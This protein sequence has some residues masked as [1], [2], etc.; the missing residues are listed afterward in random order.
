MAQEEKA[1]TKRAETGFALIDAPD[2]RAILDEAFEQF[3]LTRGELSRLKIPAGGSTTWEIED[4]KE[5]TGIRSCQELDVVV[6]GIMGNQ[7]AWWSTPVGEGG[8]DAPSCVSVDGSVGVGNNTV[9]PEA[10]RGMHKCADCPWSQWGSSRGGGGGKDCND[11]SLLFFIT[12]NEA[13]P[14]Y[15]QV[16]AT[17]LKPLKKYGLALVSARIKV[18]SLVTRLALSK[19]VSGGGHSYSTLTLSKVDDLDSEA[20]ADMDALAKSFMAK[21]TT[22][23]SLA[24]FAADSGQ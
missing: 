10:E 2:A 5:K 6:L 16:P 20:A 9:D 8:E 3:G 4:V 11:T 7:K 17:S 12:A 21:M 19:T 23:E 14:Q 13:I 15:L 1:L 24:E 22:K 18:T